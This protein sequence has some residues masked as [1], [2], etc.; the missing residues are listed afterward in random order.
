MTTLAGAGMNALEESETAGRLAAEAAL[1]PLHGR[2][3]TLLI[4][5]VTGHYD[6]TQVVRGIYAAAGRAPL[7]GCCAGGIISPQGASRHGVVV[8]ALQSDDLEIAL[9]MAAGIRQRPVEI[10]EQVADQI[11]S[12]TLSPGRGRQVM[13]LVL[14]DG[15]ATTLEE[16]V[17]STATLAGPLCPLVGGGSGNMVQAHTG[18][19]LVNDQ[20]L[21]DAL[22][23]ARLSSSA[24]IGIG[25]GHGWT[26][27]GRPLVV[28]RSQGPIVHELNGRSALA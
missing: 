16:V 12:Q 28:T 13:A 19:L 22:A 9:A 17:Q 3:P 24:P 4:V 20:V 11:E 2:S 15:A 21:L 27:V 25:V 26:P 6:P 18:S 1:A 23:M 14:A 8:L 7:L 5:F 10:S